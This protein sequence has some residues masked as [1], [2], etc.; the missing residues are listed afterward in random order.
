MLFPEFP[1]SLCLLLKQNIKPYQIVVIRWHGCVT[2]ANMIDS[3]LLCLN[4]QGSIFILVN[5]AID[6]QIKHINICYHF[7]CEFYKK[8]EME[9][10][11]ISS[12]D[13][14][15]NILIKNVS[16]LIIERFSFLLV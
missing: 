10:Y 12:E 7:I 9:I 3:T 2:L 5:S 4:N 16:L 15:A 1:L 14:L 13:Q 8:G 11:F 6:Y